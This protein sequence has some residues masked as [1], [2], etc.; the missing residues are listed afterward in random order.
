MNGSGVLKEYPAL[1]R[2]AR[3][4]L[5]QCFKKIKSTY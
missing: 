1:L 4:E 2:M 5:L 3:A